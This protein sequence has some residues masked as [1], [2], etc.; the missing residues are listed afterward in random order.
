MSLHPM[1]TES[2]MK[3]LS[4]IV[5]SLVVGATAAGYTGV[6]RAAGEDPDSATQAG[7]YEPDN[8]GRN[9]RDRDDRMPTSGDQSESEQDRKLSQKI[10]QAIV[11]DDSLSTSAHNVKIITINGVVT[12][13]GPVKNAEER[14]AIGA[15]AVKIAGAGKV[16]NHLEPTRK[17]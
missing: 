15:A 14:N 11:A 4:S 10:R 5:L 17:E 9:V 3:R 13:R 12:L 8:T 7:E 6:A 2:N 16:K 1:Q